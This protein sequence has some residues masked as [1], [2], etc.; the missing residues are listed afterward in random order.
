MST[1]PATTFCRV[2]HLWVRKSIGG[3]NA[4]GGFDRFALAKAPPRGKRS[5][6]SGDTRQKRSAEMSVAQLA[7]LRLARQL[8]WKAEAALG[9]VASNAPEH[10][11][12]TGKRSG[13]S[14]EFSFSCSGLCCEL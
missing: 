10:V 11:A 5:T 3:G 12:H 2:V 8:R 7:G 14:D 13:E 6:P 4:R 1:P 9:W